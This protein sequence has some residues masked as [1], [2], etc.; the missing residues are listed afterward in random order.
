MALSD[1]DGHAERPEVADDVR[2][3]AFGRLQVADGPGVLGA[4]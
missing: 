4:E 1:H 3:L 2:D